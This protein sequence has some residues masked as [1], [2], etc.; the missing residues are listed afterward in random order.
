M[1]AV[2]F[3][4]PKLLFAARFQRMKTGVGNHLI[5]RRGGPPVGVQHF[6]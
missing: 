5:Y 6:I 1:Q 4:L 3:F 2:E